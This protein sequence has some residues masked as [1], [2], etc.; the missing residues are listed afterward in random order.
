MRVHPATVRWGL[1]FG[2]A[3]VL[4]ACAGSDDRPPPASSGCPGGGVCP[5][6]P[7]RSGA[8]GGGE[9]GA[10][11][12]PG[13]DAGP[14]TTVTGSVRVLAN[15][16][17]STATDFIGDGIV[18]ATAAASRTTAPFSGATYTLQGVLPDAATW[19]DVQAAASP[20][21]VMSTILQADTRG[22]QV[23]LFFAT[24]TT[25]ESIGANLLFPLETR[26][27]RGH[28]VLRFVDSGGR[29]VS[30]IVVSG[31]GEAVAYD[32]GPGLFRDDEE[33]TTEA[34]VAVV[35]NAQA[36]PFPGSVTRVSYG[37][38]RSGAVDVKLAVDSATL[39]T[40]SL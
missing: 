22:G 19:M 23:D 6:T 35:L 30:G 12:A 13:V 26:V 38:S 27:D 10:G 11:G 5:G 18:G 16:E 39:L 28:L 15:E 25:F 21:D 4:L 1:L 29:G 17:F 36:L 20:L 8:S 31:I 33:A 40:V 14:T 37:G 24:R 9:A 32:T 34:G 2:A 7:P 3:T